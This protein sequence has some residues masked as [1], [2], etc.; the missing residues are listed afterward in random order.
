MLISSLRHW[1]CPRDGAFPLRPRVETWQRDEAWEGRLECP[2]CGCAYSFRQ[3]LPNFLPRD[4]PGWLEP[5]QQLE[6]VERNRALMMPRTGRQLHDERVEEAAVL[7]CLAGLRRGRILDAGCG[8]GRMSLRLLR[9]GHEVVALDFA[10]GRL[11]HLRALA[12]GRPQLNCAVAELTHA[13]L[14]ACHFDA[15]VCLQV[16]EHLPTPELRQALLDRL[17]LALLPGG[18]LVLTVYNYN[19]ARRRAGAPDARHD[20]GI[21]YHCYTET[22]LRQDLHG[23]RSLRLRGLVCR[24]PAAYR[25]LGHAGVLGRRL[26]RALTL[27]GWLARGWAHLWLVQAVK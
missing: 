10:A 5:D 8:V 13:P 14:R 21:F 23:F 17:R 20:S 26:D 27:P 11:L 24:L 16:L 25:L 9:R 2:A 7:R 4:E 18:R 12:D 1:A 6:L 3:G 22:E 19:R 15:V